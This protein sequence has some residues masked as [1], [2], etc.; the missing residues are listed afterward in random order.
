MLARVGLGVI[1][2][3]AAPASWSASAFDVKPGDKLY[4]SPG[5]RVHIW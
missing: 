4:L 5:E 3:V 1:P 2:S